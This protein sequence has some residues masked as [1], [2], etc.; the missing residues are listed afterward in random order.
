M[1][2]SVVLFFSFRLIKATLPC[3]RTKWALRF[4]Q[5]GELCREQKRNCLLDVCCLEKTF[6]NSIILAYCNTG[7][8]IAGL[9]TSLSRDDAKLLFST[10]LETENPVT[11][12]KSACAT[13]SISP[14]DSGILAVAGD[15]GS[16]RLLNYHGEWVSMTTQHF[17]A[18]VKVVGLP[19]HRRLLSL[20][21]DHRLLLWRMDD[22]FNITVQCEFKMCGLGDP[23]DLCVVPV[24]GTESQFLAMV[25][26]SGLQLCHID[27]NNAS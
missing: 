4:L 13:N 18:V 17:A 7:G 26:G 15:D 8:R 5:L 9:E 27:V 24:E 1:D 3:E 16:V 19:N 21:A 23:Q 11:H 2:S 14:V 12:K 6:D 25:S 20:G 22:N 10:T